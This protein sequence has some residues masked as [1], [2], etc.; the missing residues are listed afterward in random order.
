MAATTTRSR[1]GS[2]TPSAQPRR[3]QRPAPRGGDHPDR[4]AAERSR[5]GA[6]DDLAAAGGARDDH[7]GGTRRH[8]QDR[9][10]ASGVVG[11]HAAHQ[12]TKPLARGGGDEETR[13]LGKQRPVDGRRPA[14]QRAPGVVH[15]GA[16]GRHPARGGFAVKRPVSASTVPDQLGA[17]TISQRRKSGSRH[18]PSLPATR[19]VR[20]AP[21]DQGD[22]ASSDLESGHRRRNA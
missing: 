4:A 19:C 11:F 21:A 8:R 10:E 1:R 16:P 5:D 6:R 17:R 3:H 12:R 15:R 20:S 18:A 7:R 9:A 22:A 13:G 14:P 2:S